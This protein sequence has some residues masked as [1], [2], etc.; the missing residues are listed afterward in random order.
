MVI[1]PPTSSNDHTH[2]PAWY[3]AHEHR[4][5]RSL[6][7]THIAGE[8]VDVVVVA[9]ACPG[10]IVGASLERLNVLQGRAT[11]LEGK[12]GGWREEGGGGRGEEGKG[13]K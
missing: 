12:E 6:A 8:S 13:L 11:G 10:A 1:T 3:R 2:I 9:V 5:L 7:T 4:A